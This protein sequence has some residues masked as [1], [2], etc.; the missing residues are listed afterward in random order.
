MPM[1]FILVPSGRYFWNLQHNACQV[2]GRSGLLAFSDGVSP[3]GGNGIAWVYTH[4][5]HGVGSLVDAVGSM[6]A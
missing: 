2:L 3:R 5:L 4:R 1:A 6:M